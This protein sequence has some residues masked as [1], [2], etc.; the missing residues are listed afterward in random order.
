VPALDITS[1]LI[2]M[3]EQFLFHEAEMLDDAR[4]HDWL[5]LLESDVDYRIPTRVT[6]EHGALKSG[7]SSESFLM[8]DDFGSL[9]ARVQRFDTDFAF[10]E[11]PPTRTR[12]I[13][14]N[15]RVVAGAGDELEVKSNF[16]LFRTKLDQQSQ[17][18]AGERHDVLR[19][20]RE[21]LRLKSRVVLLE[22]TVLPMENLAI[23]L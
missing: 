1:D 16:I 20:T 14:G 18:L 19:L 21:I 11:D 3:C 17:L 2:R 6:R 10:A 22:H 8:I 23:F 7:F 12:R 4:L 15:V 13:I 5:S 9:K